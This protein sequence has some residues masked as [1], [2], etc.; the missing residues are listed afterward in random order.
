MNPFIKPIATID[1][2]T[3]C[4]PIVSTLKN[5]SILLYQICHKVN[6]AMNFDNLSWQDDIKIHVLSKNTLLAGISTLPV[7]GNI[8]IFIYHVRSAIARRYWHEMRTP[9]YLEGALK[10]ETYSLKKHGH[11]VISLYLAR[12]PKLLNE[13][14]QALCDAAREGKTEPFNLLFKTKEKW[15]TAQI[16]RLLKACRNLEILKIILR[17]YPI[18]SNAQSGDVLDYYMHPCINFDQSLA[19]LEAYPHTEIR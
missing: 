4:L 11:E 5:C 18:L 9:G 1:A 6:K 17:E 15:D 3:D 2:I 8:A 13:K 19:L 10:A 14:F 16:I 12:N 7:L